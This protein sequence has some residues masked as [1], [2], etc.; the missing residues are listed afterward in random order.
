MCEWQRHKEFLTQYL[1]LP[2]F[3]TIITSPLNTSTGICLWSWGLLAQHSQTSLQT[4]MFYVFVNFKNIIFI[5]LKDF[6]FI[7]SQQQPLS[8]SCSHGPANP[9][10][11]E[12]RGL[13]HGVKSWLGCKSQEGA[14]LLLALRNRFAQELNAQSSSCSPW[15]FCKPLLGLLL[16]HLVI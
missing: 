14:F 5:F 13:T 15:G 4:N 16:A 11:A 12:I 1:P 7:R 10:K 8:H 3:P 6:Y 2:E 9:L